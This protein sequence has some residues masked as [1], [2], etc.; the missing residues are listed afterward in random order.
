M[1]NVEYKLAEKRMRL[2]MIWVLIVAMATNFAAAL[3]IGNELNCRLE[4]FAPI[5]N[6]KI[7]FKV[8]IMAILPLLAATIIFLT[9]IGASEKEMKAALNNL[10]KIIRQYYHLAAFL[11]FIHILILI[12]ISLPTD[13]AQLNANKFITIGLSSASLFFL[14]LVNI[15]AKMNRSVFS[16]WP[17]PWNLKSDLAWEKSQRFIGFALSLASILC[18]FAVFIS[19]DLFNSIVIGGMLISY[20][21]CCIVSYYVYQQE[22]YQLEKSNNSEGK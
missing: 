22:Q 20:G 14:Y 8:I 5:C 1:G 13:M 12:Y 3:F 2:I 11:M 18:F 19:V 16:G 21:G 17:T 10:P 4:N 6:E 9:Y 7:A 15:S